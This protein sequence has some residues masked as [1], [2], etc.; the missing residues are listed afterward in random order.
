MLQAEQRGTGHALAQAESALAGQEATLL[1]LSGDV[2]L[3]TPAT[4]AELARWLRT[5]KTVKAARTAPGV[6]WPSP[7]WPSQGC[8]DG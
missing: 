5:A 2:P 8:S 3:V 6:P 1:V 7:S 4:L